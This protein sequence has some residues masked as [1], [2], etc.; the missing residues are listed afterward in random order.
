MICEKA[1]NFSNVEH[2][3]RI[4]IDLGVWDFSSIL[5]GSSYNFSHLV[6]S[7][8]EKNSKIYHPNS[9]FLNSCFFNWVF[10]ENLEYQ[11]LLSVRQHSIRF[12]H[13]NVRFN[14]YNDLVAIN[15]AIIR[16]IR[17]TFLHTISIMRCI[18]SLI[19]SINCK[20][21]NPSLFI[22]YD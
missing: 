18:F 16:Y 12:I 8:F 19:L 5:L 11:Y 20:T 17:W 10:Q 14:F 4:N 15:D 2:I 3:M 21:T 9:G 7:I 6:V 13:G 1:T 22:S